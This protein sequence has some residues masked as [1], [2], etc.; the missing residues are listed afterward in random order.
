MKGGPTGRVRGDLG[1][2]FGESGRFLLDWGKTQCLAKRRWGNPGIFEGFGPKLTKKCRFSRGIGRVRKFKAIKGKSLPKTRPE[3][4]VDFLGHFA[5]G[6]LVPKRSKH[7]EPDG[8]GFVNFLQV[9][10]RKSPH[11]S[12]NDG[13]SKR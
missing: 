11:F 4:G 2:H 1:G 13:S 9:F 10:G 8:D 3:R 12:R 6:W 5:W 7:F